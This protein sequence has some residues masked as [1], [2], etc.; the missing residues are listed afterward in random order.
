MGGK[1]VGEMR[2]DEGWGLQNDKQEDR[3]QEDRQQC[4]GQAQATGTEAT[5]GQTDRR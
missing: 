4:G 2:T 1:S 3:Y 5:G